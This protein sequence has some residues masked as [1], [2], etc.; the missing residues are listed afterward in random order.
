MARNSDTIRMN[1]VSLMALIGG[2]I[3]FVISGA[4]VDVIWVA[5]GACI[6]AGVGVAI[7]QYGQGARRYAD[8]VDLRE[9]A[10]RADLLEEARRLD[11]P[12]RSN[13]DKDQ[14]VQAIDERRREAR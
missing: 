9:S 4:I 12:G 5:I 8:A 3:A 7:R 11:V 1:P 14:L 10:T 2:V 6:G 13:M